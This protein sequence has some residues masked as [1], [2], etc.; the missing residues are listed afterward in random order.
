MIWFYFE[1]L[2]DVLINQSRGNHSEGVQMNRRNQNKRFRRQRW[3]WFT[4]FAFA[5]CHRPCFLLSHSLPLSIFYSCSL[6][7][8]CPPSVLASLVSSLFFFLPPP[9]L[10]Y[11]STHFCFLWSVKNDHLQDEV[12]RICQ[13]NGLTKWIATFLAIHHRFEATAVKI[14]GRCWLIDY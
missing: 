10:H 2:R 13:L 4:S 7:S 11:P 5:V 1:Q 14:C 3:I 9:P 6:L 8:F 12:D